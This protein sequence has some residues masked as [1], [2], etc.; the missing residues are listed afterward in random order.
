LLHDVDEMVAG[1]R[2]VL[3]SWLGPSR[4]GGPKQGDDAD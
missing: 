2:N 4:D 3:G 1:E